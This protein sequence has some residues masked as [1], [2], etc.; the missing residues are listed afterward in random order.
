MIKYHS[1]GGLNNRILC[2]AIWEAEQSKVRVPADL[3]P[4]EKSLP[5]S[6]KASVLS[7]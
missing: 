6:Y 4:G 5:G 7:D 2:F 1:L 3:D